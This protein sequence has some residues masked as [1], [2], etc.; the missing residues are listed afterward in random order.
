M[1]LGVNNISLL[2]DSLQVYF[3][4]ASHRHII[5]IVLLCNMICLIYIYDI[6]YIY[7]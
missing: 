7:M 5:Y 6:W 3:L 2:G 4:G 1:F